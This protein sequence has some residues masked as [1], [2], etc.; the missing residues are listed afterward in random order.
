MTRT[1]SFCLLSLHRA[2]QIQSSMVHTSPTRPTSI[3]TGIIFLQEKDF[4]QA[5]SRSL[6]YHPYASV[7]IRGKYFQLVIEWWA[8]QQT[9]HMALTGSDFTDTACTA[10]FIY[11][12]PFRWSLMI[13]WMIMMK[14]IRNLCAVTVVS[15]I[16]METGP[17]VCP[18]LLCQATH[19]NN[20]QWMMIEE[21]DTDKF[22]TEIS[23]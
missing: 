22:K 1:P 19:R 14:I 9:H 17:E 8:Y 12:L 13:S 4:L 6:Y 21:N 5:N 3:G 18:A 23:I 16:K 2:S 20:L 10:V 11:G 7:H 15:S